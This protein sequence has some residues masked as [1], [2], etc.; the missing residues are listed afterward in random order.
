MPTSGDAPGAPAAAPPLPPSPDSRRRSRPAQ[1]RGRQNVRIG[2]A[3]GAA[4][5]GAVFFFND[6]APPE[7]YT[8]PLPDALPIWKSPPAPQ[9]ASF[10]PGPCVSRRLESRRLT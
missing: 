1:E 4:E 6:T 10:R 3:L 7:I 5:A 8:L 2:K 9:L